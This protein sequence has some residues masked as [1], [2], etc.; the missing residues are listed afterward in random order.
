MLSKV[1]VRDTPVYSKLAGATSSPRK[2]GEQFVDANGLGGL[3]TV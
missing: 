2:S 1:R 3:G